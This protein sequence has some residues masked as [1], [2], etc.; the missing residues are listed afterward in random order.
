M[1]TGSKCLW[2][3]TGF[4]DESRLP[5]SRHSTAAVGRDYSG[6]VQYVLSIWWTLWYVNSCRCSCGVLLW[7][8]I[9]MTLHDRCP[10]AIPPMHQH[11]YSSMNKV[12]QLKNII[13]NLCFMQYLKFPQHQNDVAPIISRV[14]FWWESSMKDVYRLVLNYWTHIETSHLH[15]I[16]ALWLPAIKCFVLGK[17]E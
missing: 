9:D 8:L 3:H 14:H 17:W 11:Y 10:I 13:Y 2:A 4:L 5:D 12:I 7:R 6:E 15:I 1:A 16:R